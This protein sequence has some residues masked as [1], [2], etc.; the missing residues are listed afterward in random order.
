MENG[1]R[2]AKKPT[3]LRFGS[4]RLREGSLKGW[5]QVD[6]GGGKE[7]G[8]RKRCAFDQQETDPSRRRA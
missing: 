6:V 1:W 3:V 7:K 5:L 4:R 2:G 8:M